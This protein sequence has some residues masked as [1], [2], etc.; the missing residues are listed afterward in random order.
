MEMRLNAKPM[1]IK[2]ALTL[3]LSVLVI[4]SSA[5]S[6]EEVL[7]INLEEVLK[8]AGADNLTIEEYQSRQTLALAELEK[9]KEWWLPSIYGGIQTHQLSGATMN[10]NGV[11]FLDV[12]R[13]SL[14]LGLGAAVNLDFAKGIHSKNAAQYQLQA[15]AFHTEVEKNKILL[16]CIAAYYDMITTR[17]N[18]LAYKGLVAQSDTIIQQIEVKVL[19]GMLFESELLLAKSNK[20][21]LRVAML[22]AEINQNKAS[23]KL[24][25]LLNLKP[26]VKLV[27]AES[28][29]LPLDYSIELI[30]PSDSIFKNRPEIKANELE[31]SALNEKI[32]IHTRGLW[33][34]KLSIGANASYFGRIYGQVTPAD[35]ISYPNPT[36]LYPTASFNTSLIWDIPLGAWTHQG[37]EKRHIGM[38]QL[39]QLEGMQ[40]EAQINNE[41]RLA[42]LQIQSGKTQIDIAKE[43]LELTTKALS[44]SMDRQSQRTAKPFEVFQAQQFYLQA[45]IDYLKAVSE[46]NKAQFSLKVAKGEV[47]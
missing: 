13:N 47:L 14:W 43:G 22:N 31:I 34:P 4:C 41:V 39:K 35:P 16:E 17:S 6:Q 42:T 7:S 40:Y 46:F 27:I 28:A 23:S 21:H 5:Y 37:D 24:Q 18:Y 36:Q 45:Q 9:A 2:S 33:I 25:L 1:L 20:N 3:F 44:Q 29:L 12:N 26:G 8:L 19:A 38:I 30:D 15:S 32:L 10:S 11:Y